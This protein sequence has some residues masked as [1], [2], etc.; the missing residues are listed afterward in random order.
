VDSAAAS[1]RGRN[2]SIPGCDLL[3]GPEAAVRCSANEPDLSTWHRC[4]LAVRLAVANL[5]V[6]RPINDCVTVRT[7]PLIWPEDDSNPGGGTRGA[8]VLYRQPV[9]DQW[10]RCRKCQIPL[11][12]PDRTGPDQTQSVG[13]A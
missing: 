9:I 8:G 4:C 7:A 3:P 11:H 1:G 13:S 5:S 2:L 12:G 10:T 6:A